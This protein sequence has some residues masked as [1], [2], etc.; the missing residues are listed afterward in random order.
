MRVF[1]AD[2]HRG[3]DVFAFTGRLPAGSAGEV[4][5]EGIGIAP[6]VAGAALRAGLRAAEA[7]HELLEDVL[8]RKAR[9][10]GGTPRTARAGVEAGEFRV[11]V[12]V[13]FAAVIGCLLVLVGQEIIGRR[14]F[15]ELLLRLGVVFVLVG[16]VGLGQLAVSRLQILLAHRT[17]NPEHGVGIAHG[18]LRYFN[19]D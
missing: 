4:R 15:G 18:F 8:G 3:V 7:A 19:A 9:P 6:R 11:A 5:S 1:E 14:H 2:R 16:V 12:G 13:D 10:V 17:R